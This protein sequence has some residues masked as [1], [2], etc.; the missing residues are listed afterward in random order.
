MPP[1]VRTAAALESSAIPLEALRADGR[2]ELLEILEMHP[3][4]ELSLSTFTLALVTTH[5]HAHLNSFMLCAF[6]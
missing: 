5:A 6:G 3:G 1:K 4:T 2:S